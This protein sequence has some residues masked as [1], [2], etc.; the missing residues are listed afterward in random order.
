[1]TLLSGA[2]VSFPPSHVQSHLQ[3]RSKQCFL[4]GEFS[5]K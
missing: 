1:M 2:F 4:I 5:E 3:S